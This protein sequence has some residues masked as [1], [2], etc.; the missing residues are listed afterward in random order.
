MA[1]IASPTSG[2]ARRIPAIAASRG[3]LR[4]AAIP[5]VDRRGDDQRPVAR[6][7]DPDQDGPAS[8][9]EVA[10][11][12]RA[13]PPGP[14]RPPAPGPRARVA[15]RNGWKTVTR[16][17]PT[18]STARYAS[19]RLARFT[20]IRRASRILGARARARAIDRARSDPRP[21]GPAPDS[22]PRPAI[23]S[24]RQVE[25]SMCCGPW[26]ITARSRN[27]SGGNPSKSRPPCP[28]IRTRP[29]SQGQPESPDR[30]RRLASG[31]PRIELGTDP[32]DAPRDRQGQGKLEPD[33]RMDQRGQAEADRADPGPSLRVFDASTPAPASRARSRPG[34]RATS[35]R[36]GGSCRCSPPSPPGRGTTATKPDLPARSRARPRGPAGR[37]RGSS[38]PGS[39]QTA[40]PAP[41]PGPKGRLAQSR[42]V[43]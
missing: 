28:S 23:A 5:S 15:I 11:G 29:G 4:P 43:R 20:A 32:P 14:R 8:A 12:P 3:P 37:L 35:P 33:R 2:P 25:G 13:R 17:S 42:S 26:T 10:L 22:T 30:Q 19:A 40:R 9:R 6:E 27:S 39:T 41:P 34:G 7:P 21:G 16:R 36:T 38:P 31:S 1:R 24:V 18:T